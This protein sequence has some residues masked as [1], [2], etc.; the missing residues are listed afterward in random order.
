MEQWRIDGLL[1][2]VTD[3]RIPFVTK[4]LQNP[5]SCRTPLAHYTGDARVS[6]PYQ[7]QT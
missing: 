7:A 2:G 5:R 6:F 3:E 4:K 1:R